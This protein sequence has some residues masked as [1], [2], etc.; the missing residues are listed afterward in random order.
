M[1]HC[2]KSGFSVLLLLLLMISLLCACGIQG[3]QAE[4]GS[5]VTGTEQAPQAGKESA[6]AVSENPVSMKPAETAEADSTPPVSQEELRLRLVE[7]ILNYSPG[8]AGS[9]LKLAIAATDVLS[10]AAEYGGN[11]DLSLIWAELPE[12]EQ[13]R[14]Q[15][16]V[17]AI[18]ELLG[19]MRS[20]YDSVSGLFEDAGIK[21]Q[22]ERL[23][24]QAG[25]W[26][27]WDQL[28]RCL[29]NPEA[30]SGTG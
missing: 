5:T 28:Y 26:E 17:D 2:G 7:P 18:A 19:I 10:F 29:K 11:V 8:T 23:A 3:R 20:N 9:S 27:N 30:V 14:F 16:N 4:P 12:E 22:A 24:G 13:A 6:D 1:S 15:E 21:E 25:V